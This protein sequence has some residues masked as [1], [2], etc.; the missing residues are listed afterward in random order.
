MSTI[1]AFLLG[2]LINMFAVAAMFFWRFWRQTRDLLFLAFSVAFTMEGLTR[3]PLLFIAHAAEGSPWLYSVRMF[4]SVLIVAA[5]LDKNYR[6]RGREGAR[7]E[8]R[9]ADRRAR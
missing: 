5:I 6:R 2:F 4:A 1:E 7:A 3:I 9:A 8:R